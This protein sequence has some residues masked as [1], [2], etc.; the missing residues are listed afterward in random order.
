MD[1]TA[2]RGGWATHPSELP[3]LRGTIRDQ[4][5]STSSRLASRASLP[6]RPA[7]KT[8][9]FRRFNADPQ[10][11]QS[12]GRRESA[13]SRPKTSNRR[14]SRPGTGLVL[15]HF[16]VDVTILGNSLWFQHRSKF[17]VFVHLSLEQPTD[18]TFI[19][20]K[21]LSGTRFS[22]IL[23]KE[24]AETNQ[25]VLNAGT[26]GLRNFLPQLPADGVFLLHHVDISPS[27]LRASSSSY[28]SSVKYER[29]E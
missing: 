29:F 12:S 26:A 14:E 24:K 4:E 15:S 8:G 13:D 21:C 6:S 11:P 2:S 1:R 19:L 10:K 27:G 23:L 18:S 25:C 3:P 5:P 7:S 28:S 20:T 9:F 16:S 22:F 17:S